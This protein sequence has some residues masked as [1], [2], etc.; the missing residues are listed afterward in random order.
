MD[1]TLGGSTPLS[2]V[3]TVPVERLHRPLE[4]ARARLEELARAPAAENVF[5]LAAAYGD[6]GQAQSVIEAV[7][8]A[9]LDALDPR[10][11][12]GVAQPRAGYDVLR[13]RT[14]AALRR[15]G[16]IFAHLE[17]QFAGLVHGGAAWPSQPVEV[18]PDRGDGEPLR[19]YRNTYK[20]PPGLSP[21]QREAEQARRMGEF[22]AA[23]GDPGDILVADGELM[24]SLRDRE[25]YDYVLRADGSLRLYSNAP[26]V[27]PKPGHS[28]LAAGLPGD[29][30]DA[31]V[32]LAG[33][34]WIYRDTAGDLEALV[35]ANNS[36]H[37]K[38]RYEDLENAIPH[39]EALGIPAAKIVT[40]GGPN[41]LPALF[42]EMA[43]QAGLEDPESYQPEDP[44]VLLGQLRG[45]GTRTPLTVRG[46]KALPG[47]G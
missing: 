32:L 25:R 20:R 33:E 3:P 40:F 27:D 42:M 5:E 17:P 31:P 18:S 1:P 2:R 38:P 36:G 21:E 47:H 26:E 43:G 7:L 22:V 39:L 34:L 10:T 8:V 35:I 37:F 44:A 46:W 45:G 28:L 15:A 6:L 23:G 11:G 16:Q 19:Y 41:N 9:T 4:E 24:A 30:A 29:D 14:F 13:A 12:G